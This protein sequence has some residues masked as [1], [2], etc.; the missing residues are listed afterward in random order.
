[1]YSLIQI[2]LILHSVEAPLINVLSHFDNQKVCEI[3]LNE[4]LKRNLEGGNKAQMITDNENNKYLKIEIN[5]EDSI[6][7]WYCKQTIFYK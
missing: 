5:N 3:K 1:M 6:S 7:Y 4:T 2:I